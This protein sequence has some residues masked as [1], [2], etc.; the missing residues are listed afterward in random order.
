MTA[1]AADVELR[2]IAYERP[3]NST[4]CVLFRAKRS[5]STVCQLGLAEIAR[6]RLDAFALSAATVRSFAEVLQRQFG[7]GEPE[8][9]LVH[10]PA[11]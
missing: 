9:G 2:L 3:A 7:S 8:L 6:S 1:E 11:K 5:V 10:W 4:A